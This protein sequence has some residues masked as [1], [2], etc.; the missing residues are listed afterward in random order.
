MKTKVKI[1]MNPTARI[2]RDHGL[3][4]GGKVQM[5]H[6]QNV[7][8]RITKYMPYKS[9]ATIK[10]TIAQTDIRRPQIVTDAPYAKFLFY[11]KLMLSDVTG[12]A[13]AR[14]DETKHVV[15]KALNYNQTKNP[16]AGPRWDRAV[17]AA[18]GPA[19]AADLQKFI[20]RGGK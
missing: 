2:L 4:A 12:S 10:L 6:T 18:E 11:G 8:R 15:N 1:K 7:L 16:L 9:N 13:W 20:K 14:K 19:M 5:F 3:D 17:S